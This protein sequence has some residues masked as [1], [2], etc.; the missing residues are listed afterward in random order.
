MSSLGDGVTVSRS[1]SVLDFLQ[2][3]WPQ[4]FHFRHGITGAVHPGNF[5]K[6]R[7]CCILLNPQYAPLWPLT[8]AG[9]LG[10]IGNGWLEEEAHSRQMKS[11][12]GIRK[13]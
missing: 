3:P 1:H 8:H 11:A 2:Q 12:V 7:E 6:L 13:R 4:I 9:M 10:E 5:Q